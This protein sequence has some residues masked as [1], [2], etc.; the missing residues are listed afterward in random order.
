MEAAPM[1]E[2][3]YTLLSGGIFLA[4]GLLRLFW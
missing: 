4:M 2:N 3:R 1:A